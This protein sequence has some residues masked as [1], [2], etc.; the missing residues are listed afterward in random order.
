MA[1]IR[2]HCDYC[3]GEWEVYKHGLT[4]EHSRECPHCFHTVNEQ[5]WEKEIIPAFCAVDEANAELYKEHLGEH[6]PLFYFDVVANHI[7]KNGTV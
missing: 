4:S 6:K 5:L 7:F 1:F 2:I 3:G